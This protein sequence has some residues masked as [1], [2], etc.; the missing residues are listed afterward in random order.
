M[1]ERAVNSTPAE[2]GAWYSYAVVRLVPRVDRGEFINVG[3]VLFSRTLGF[4]EA[5]IELDEPRLRAIAGEVN[6]ERLQRHLATFQAI[7]AGDAAGGPVAGMD[8]S[9][10]FHWLTA[11]RSTIIQT[12][13]VH[14]GYCESPR[15]LIEELM[16]QLV[17]TAPA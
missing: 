11:P 8:R 6:L 9:A 15:R 16:D 1:P 17:R 7:A 2:P 12:S 3:I 13:P 4:L 5:R 14:V 10:R